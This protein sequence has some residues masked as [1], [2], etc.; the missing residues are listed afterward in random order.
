M[1]QELAGSVEV[2]EGYHSRFKM[3]WVP[4]FLSKTTWPALWKVIL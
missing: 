2:D 1:N 4:I 3:S